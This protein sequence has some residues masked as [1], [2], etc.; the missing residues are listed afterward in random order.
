MLKLC[1]YIS[2]NNSP[3]SLLSYYSQLRLFKEKK[4]QHSQWIPAER[5]QNLQKYFV[6]KEFSQR[7]KS[8]IDEKMPPYLCRP[9]NDCRHHCCVNVRNEEGLVSYPSF[10]LPLPIY[11]K[12]FLCAL[13]DIVKALLCHPSKVQVNDRW[14]DASIPVSAVQWSQK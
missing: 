11:L 3:S 1:K 12:A 13:F 9:F 4:R 10:L 7:Y 14:E 8:M 2:Q 6:K 5:T